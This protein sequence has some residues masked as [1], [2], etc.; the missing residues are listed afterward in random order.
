M[1]FLF[2]SLQ[3]ICAAAWYTVGTETMA[4]RH[5]VA[6]QTKSG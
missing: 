6:K 4:V 5:L 2:L 1:H 3:N